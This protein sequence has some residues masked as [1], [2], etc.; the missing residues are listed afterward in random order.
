MMSEPYV[1]TTNP[2]NIHSLENEL[3]VVDYAT[4]PGDLQPS[5]SRIIRVPDD[6][7]GHTLLI[8]QSI[9]TL[10]IDNVNMLSLVNGVP[11]GLNKYVLIKDNTN[12]YG[13]AINTPEPFISMTDPNTAATPFP[14]MYPESHH[15][16]HAVLLM[17]LQFHPI[18]LP[19]QIT[20]LILILLV[21]FLLTITMWDTHIVM[22]P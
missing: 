7:N 4:V 17:H 13:K 10:L 8:E 14:P 20:I 9:N 3:Y 21:V 6:S 16:L 2:V 1:P 11:I 15:S 12:E 22:I 5:L 18:L 19:W